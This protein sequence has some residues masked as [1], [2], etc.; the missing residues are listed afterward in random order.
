MGRHTKQTIDYFPHYVHHGKTLFIL[1]ALYKNDGYA[2]FYKLLELLGDSDGHYYDCRSETAK[3]FL[4]AKTGV[5]WIS[6]SEILKRLSD[7]DII[8]KELWKKGVI[9]MET[10]VESIKDAY[11]KRSISVPEKPQASVF[12]PPEIKETL[13]LDVFPTSEVHKVNKSKVNKSKTF[14]PNSIELR[15][16]EHFFDLIRKNNPQAKEPNKQAWAK[17]IDLM[18][19]VDNRTPENIRRVMEWCQKDSFWLKNVLSTDKLRD[20]FDELYLKMGGSNGRD[21][22]SSTANSTENDPYAGIGRHIDS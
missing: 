14:C 19:R 17:H 8:D 4:A 20:K 18:I 5:E 6:A 16:A 2:F 10:F 12:L 1:E 21:S 9:W 22:K 13:P 11:R 3:E 7:M 15:L